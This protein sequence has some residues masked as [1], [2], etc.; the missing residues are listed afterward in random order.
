M[1]QYLEIIEQLTLEERKIKQPQFIRIE[2]IS[3]EDALSKLSIYEP[4]FENL[5]YQ[6]R[7]HKCFHPEEQPCEIELL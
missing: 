3:K 5:N 1:K 2:V 7:L 6:K 4:I